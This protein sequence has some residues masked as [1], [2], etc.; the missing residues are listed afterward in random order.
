MINFTLLIINNFSRTLTT[1]GY[2]LQNICPFCKFF[3][4]FCT[5]SSTEGR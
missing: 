2:D 1:E 3:K 5:R 4:Y